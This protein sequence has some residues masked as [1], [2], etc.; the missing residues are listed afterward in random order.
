MS[1]CKGGWKKRESWGWI[2]T[3]VSVSMSVSVSEGCVLGRM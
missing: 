3:C 1:P 2:F